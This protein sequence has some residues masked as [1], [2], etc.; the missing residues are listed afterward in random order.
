MRNNRIAVGHHRLGRWSPRS[1]GAIG[2]I[3]SSILVA[4]LA[5]VGVIDLAGAES[6]FDP[7]RPPDDLMMEAPAAKGGSATTSGNETESKWI[8]QMIRTGGQEAKALI[9]GRLVRIGDTIDGLKVTAIGRNEVSGVSQAKPIQLQM[10][11]LRPG[12]GITI[13]RRTAPGQP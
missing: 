13:R 3:L 6:F 12:Q 8:V 5:G 10:A 2:T 9:N 11:V 4:C 1:P 7:S